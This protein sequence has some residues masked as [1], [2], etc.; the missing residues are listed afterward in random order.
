ML[1]PELEHIFPGPPANL[2]RIRPRPLRREVADGSARADLGRKLRNYLTERGELGYR[3][4]VIGLSGGVDSAVCAQL[5]LDAAPSAVR[6][7]V[8][9]LDDAP[10]ETE[11]GMQCASAMGV[12]CTV[13]KGREA[14][15]AQL[16]V[17]PSTSVM[18]R[19]HVRSR[20]ITSLLFQV[21][22]ECEGLVIDT[23]DR[24]E[25]L[26]GLYEEGRRGNVAPVSGLYKSE[27][28]AMAHEMG[29]G[30]FSESGCP[31]LRNSD[32]F[33]LQWSQLDAILELLARAVP[34]DSIARRSGLETA[35]IKAL[36]RR[37]R[38]QPLRTDHVALTPDWH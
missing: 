23:T 19:I 3:C 28:Y 9:E 34:I 25:D 17:A 32:A 30:D 14:L 33:G 26:L 24:S 6:A 7:V 20:L 38:L 18:G 15:D 12:P 5:A 4:F 13:V 36:E 2:G 27:L 11:L 21:A 1:H 10:E 35:W 29:L 37:M 8:V 31:D 22:N 16:R